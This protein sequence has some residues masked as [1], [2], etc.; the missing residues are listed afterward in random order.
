V[1]VAVPPEVGAIRQIS[2]THGKTTFVRRDPAERR[3]AHQVPAIKARTFALVMARTIAFG[4]W[5]LKMAVF[6]MSEF[7][8]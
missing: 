7:I 8:L 2:A 5:Q 6:R 3:L 1:A 4:L